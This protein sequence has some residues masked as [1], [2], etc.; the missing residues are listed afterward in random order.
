MQSRL[1]KPESKI[2]R[3]PPRSSP[4]ASGSRGLG[5]A[6]ARRAGVHG[7]GVGKRAACN[8]GLQR[9]PPFPPRLAPANNPQIKAGRSVRGSQGR[10]PNPRVPAP[11]LQGFLASLIFMASA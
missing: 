1:V 9:F 8:L 2:S 7:G 6:E 4:G 3:A 11:I 10:L 5:A